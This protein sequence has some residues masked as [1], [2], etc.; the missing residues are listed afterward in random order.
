MR[1]KDYVL[2]YDENGAT[3]VEGNGNA[4]ANR[5]YTALTIQ[6]GTLISDYEYGSE[7]Y[8]IKKNLASNELAAKRYCENALSKIT[9]LEQVSVN[10]KIENERL[11][12]EIQAIAN[13][14]LLRNNLTI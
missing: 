10:A 11:N 9:Q 8:S 1:N 6:K 2:L 5:I 13:G 12:I 7:L 14:K 4:L 3:A